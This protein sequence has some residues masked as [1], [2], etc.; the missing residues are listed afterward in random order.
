MIQATDG[1]HRG[2]SND[3]DSQQAAVPSSVREFAHHSLAA[4]MAQGHHATASHGG[5]AS[6][7]RQQ[8]AGKSTPCCLSEPV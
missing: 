7:D 5:D 2:L 4:Q 1:Q 6:V 3:A 8:P